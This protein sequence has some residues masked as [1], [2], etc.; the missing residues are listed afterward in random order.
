MVNQTQV[1]GK[2]ER[3]TPG[4]A[5]RQNVRSLVHDVITLAELQ[6]QLLSVDVRETTSRLGVPAAALFCGAVL[7]LGAVPVLLLSVGWMLVNYG[8]LSEPLA[9]L[10]TALSA[11]LV[12]GVLFWAAWSRFTSALGILSRSRKELTDNIQWL[13]K[14]LSQRGSSD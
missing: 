14:T 8:G 13:K 7:A 3:Q 6:T 10:V 5:V 4:R 2:T 1:N 11:L 9:F 12:A